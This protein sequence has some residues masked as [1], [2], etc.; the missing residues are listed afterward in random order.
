MTGES[1]LLISKHT[2]VFS[3]DGTEAT[4]YGDDYNLAFV[5]PDYHGTYPVVTDIEISGFTP[6]EGKTYVNNS[7]PG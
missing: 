2:A 5:F 4:F 6:F 3:E 7:I 1:E